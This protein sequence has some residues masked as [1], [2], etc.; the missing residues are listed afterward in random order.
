MLLF[1]LKL[2]RAVA[3]LFFFEYFSSLVG[4]LRGLSAVKV[5]SLGRE[6]PMMNLDLGASSFSKR[7]KLSSV[8]EL[9]VIILSENR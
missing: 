1:I 6:R 2:A 9:F 4:L 3:Y 7:S 8:T 5:L